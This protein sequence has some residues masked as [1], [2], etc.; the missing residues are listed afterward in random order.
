MAAQRSKLYPL[1]IIGL[2]CMTLT[3]EIAQADT[4]GWATPVNLSNSPNTW[5]AEAQLAADSLGGVHIV[6]GEDTVDATSTRSQTRMPS[7]TLYYASNA[8]TGWSEPIDIIISPEGKF[9]FPVRLRAHQGM[10]YLLWVNDGALSVSQAAIGQAD[11]ATDWQSFDIPTPE[12]VRYA[13][14]VIYGDD[15]LLITYTTL[16]GAVYSAVVSFPTYLVKRESLIWRPDDPS[17]FS[18]VTLRTDVGDDGVWHVTWTITAEELDW[19]S[20]AVAYTRSLDE[21]LTWQDDWQIA[22]NGDDATV[23][24]SG[25]DV[26]VLWNRSA[27]GGSRPFRY[28]ANGGATW[29]DPVYLYPGYGGRTGFPGVDFDSTGRLHRLSST[30]YGVG[31]YHSS[32]IDDQWTDPLPIIAPGD[33]TGERPT[34]VVNSGN[35]LNAAWLDFSTGDIWYTFKI[36]DAPELPPVPFRADPVTT[37]SDGP[38]DQQTAP[39]E[40]TTPTPL[41]PSVTVNSTR[42]PNSSTASPVLV[43]GLLSLGVVLVVVIVQRRPRRR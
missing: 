5:S 43:G 6:W 1:V 21:G 42:Q 31:L 3:T 25:S 13:D 12:Q 37:Q 38:A 14:F 17:S 15:T 24:S 4:G 8:G 27:E 26:Y 7:D 35:Q 22:D 19:N 9:I 23:I 32:A 18:T 29:Y 41:P 30:F 10:L 34:F 16:D 2:V 33:P 20:Y 28:S 11:S 40:E 39:S 36:T